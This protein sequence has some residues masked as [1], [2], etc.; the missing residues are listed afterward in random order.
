MTTS[1]LICT[2]VSSVF[3][4][5]IDSMFYRAICTLV[6]VLL[7][8]HCCSCFVVVDVL[9]LL[10]CCNCSCIDIHVILLMCYC[11]IM[12]LL[13]C[14]SC[15]CDVVYALLLFTC[16]SCSC[17]VVVVV[18]RLLVQIHDELLLEVPDTEIDAVAGEISYSHL[19]RML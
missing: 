19:G 2:R 12:L 6:L 8:V 7:F 18:C 1:G 4:S 10:M 17:V 13:M 9:Q 15:S 5:C 16:C 3:E 14:C 11:S